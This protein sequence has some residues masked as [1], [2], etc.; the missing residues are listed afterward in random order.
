[1][2]SN[3]NQEKIIAKFNEIQEEILKIGWQGVLEK[4]HPD[5]NCDD[6]GASETFKLY[7][8]IYEDMK[9]RIIIS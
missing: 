5:A 7:R 3:Q 8:H 4:Y 6:P 1:M 2:Q 9:K